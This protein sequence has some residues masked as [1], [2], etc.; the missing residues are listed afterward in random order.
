MTFNNV[1][2]WL[3]SVM[4]YPRGFYINGRTS[5]QPAQLLELYEFEA[6]P[7]CRK[8]REVL[9]ELDISYLNHPCARGSN[10]RETVIARGGKALFPYL[11]DPNTNTELYESN[12][13]I[14]Y[15][16]KTYGS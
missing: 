4:R 12:D 16:H 10:Q 9:S 14:A 6:C 2:S 13:I 1:H 15:L 5:S 8:V 11:V 3:T 7:F